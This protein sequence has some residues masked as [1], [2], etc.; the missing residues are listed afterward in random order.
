MEPMVRTVGFVGS[1]WREMRCCSV[2]TRSAAATTGSAV[3]WGYAA[4]P[5][6]PRTVIDSASDARARP[7]RRCP[8]RP[9]GSLLARLQHQHQWQ[10]PTRLLQRPGHGE[11][12]GEVHVVAAG[13]HHAAR[14]APLHVGP[15]L[16]RQGIHLGPQRHGWTVRRPDPDDRAAHLEGVGVHAE[17]GERGGRRVVLVAAEPRLGVQPPAQLD[18]V[19]QVCSEPLEQGEMQV[20]P[21]EALHAR[22]V[23]HFGWSSVIPVESEVPGHTRTRRGI[24]ALSAVAFLADADGERRSSR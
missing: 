13:V 7:T 4:W 23:S 10:R 15:L 24:S 5:G 3:R 20:G 22:D 1:T 21:G 18:G 16:D 12:R 8:C 9:T 2:P 19:G 11:R 6:R 17:G 14:R